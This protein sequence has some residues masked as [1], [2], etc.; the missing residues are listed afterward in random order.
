MILIK[1]TE[2][3]CLWDI[4]SPPSFLEG[5]KCR[6]WCCQSY[7]QEAGDRL[8]SVADRTE[9]KSPREVAQCRIANITD[10]VGEKGC[11]RVIQLSLHTAKINP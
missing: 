7:Q 2:E 5:K 8:N 10:Y 9:V 11:T 4:F 6:V 1:A 3:I